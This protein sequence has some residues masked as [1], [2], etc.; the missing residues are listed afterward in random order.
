MSG[1]VPVSEGHSTVTSSR[2]ALEG[3]C[4]SLIRDTPVLPR[5]IPQRLEEIQPQGSGYWESL[6]EGLEL[7]R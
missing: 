5:L 7:W 1:L 3:R 2:M 4:S 6:G